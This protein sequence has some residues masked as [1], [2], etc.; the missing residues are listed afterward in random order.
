MELHPL[1]LVLSFILTWGIGLAPPLLIRFKFNKEPMG[2]W[3][4]IGTCT[5]LWFVNVMLFAALGSQSKNH[6]ALI[7]VAFVSYWIL[8]KRER[9]LTEADRLVVSAERIRENND[10]PDTLTGAAWNGDLAK[11]RL[12]LEGG[13]DVNQV[14]SKGQTALDL[15]RA[16]RDKQLINLLLSHG[17][18]QFGSKKNDDG[19]HGL[20]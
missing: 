15:A 6:G 3:P 13:A 11:V 19:M 1:E 2:K 18:T 14:N 16:R 5:F 8:T 10:S 12:L 20:G 4:A 9:V 17:A 7:L